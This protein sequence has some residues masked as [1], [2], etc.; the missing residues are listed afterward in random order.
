MNS[1]LNAQNIADARCGPVRI[2]SA[3]RNPLLP[4]HLQDDRD[5][6]V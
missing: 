6:D 4:L 2:P 5:P 1:F 3:W